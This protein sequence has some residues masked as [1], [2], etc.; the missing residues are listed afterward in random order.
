MR[1]RNIP[2]VFKRYEK[3]VPGHRVQVDVKF[4]NFE[5]ANKRIKKF[6]YTAID[7][8]TRIRAIKIYSRHTQENAIDFINYVIKKFLFRIHTIQTDNGHAFQ[9][10]VHW[11]KRI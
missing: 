1:K 2:S 11:H 3:Q 5:K 6:Q 4:L 8:S 7:D 10:K 9:A